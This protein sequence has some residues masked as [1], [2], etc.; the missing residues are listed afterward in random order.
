MR[1][2][3]CMAKTNTL[4]RDARQALGLTQ[5]DVAVAAGM[6]ITN[7]QSIEAGKTMPGVMFAAAIARVLGKSVEELWQFE[8]VS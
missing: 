4:I 7:F 5:Q 2:L 8:E 1:Y 3:G 6:T